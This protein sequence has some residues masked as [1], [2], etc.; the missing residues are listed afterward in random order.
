MEVAVVYVIPKKIMVLYLEFMV[1]SLSLARGI[2]PRNAL[3]AVRVFSHSL[4]KKL[5]LGIST[6]S[7]QLT[8]DVQGVF[9]RTTKLILDVNREGSYLSLFRVSF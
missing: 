3:R 9:A 7:Y 2:I 6:H 5:V 4:I 8:C 1:L